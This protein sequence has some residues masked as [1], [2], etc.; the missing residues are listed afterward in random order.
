MK[1][2]ILITGGRDFTDT[3]FI[4][5]VLDKVYY[6]YLE[7]IHL[8]LG[9][10]SGVDTLAQCWATNKK[11]DHE[12]IYAEW[13]KY[14]KRAGYLRNMEMVHKNPDLAIIFPGGI[15]TSMMK[16]ICNDYKVELI[17]P[18]YD[19]EINI[20]DNRYLPL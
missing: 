20:S 6:D 10:A 15:G 19:K 18:E 17:E 12:V 4:D 16:K 5:S 7:E 1:T 3:E 8:I 9:G 2:R 14:G 11:V 13:K